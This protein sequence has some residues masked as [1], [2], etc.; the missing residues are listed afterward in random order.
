MMKKT[1][2]AG[3]PDKKN[4]EKKPKKKKIILMRLVK[5]MHQRLMTLLILVTMRK[6]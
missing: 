3:S 6:Y 2:V 1:E 4:A 5:I